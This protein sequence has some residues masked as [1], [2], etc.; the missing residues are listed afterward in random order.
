MMTRDKI[1]SGF[2]SQDEDITVVMTLMM[3]ASVVTMSPHPRHDTSDIDIAPLMTFLCYCVPG[4]LAQVPSLA[5]S[6]SVI[7]CCMI[8]AT[9]IIAKREVIFDKS[10]NT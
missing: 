8:T 6:G 7:I 9:L 5:L 10:I 2:E 1:W 3:D 4:S